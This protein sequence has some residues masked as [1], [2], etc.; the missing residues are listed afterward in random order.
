MLNIYIYLFIQREGRERERDHVWWFRCCRFHYLVTQRFRCFCEVASHKWQRK[1]GFPTNNF[2]I[3]PSSAD[4]SLLWKVPET[5]TPILENSMESSGF[6]HVRGFPC[7]GHVNFW[8]DPNL[9]ALCCEEILGTQEW[10]QA[11]E[12][13]RKMQEIASWRR[14]IFQL[15]HVEVWVTK[16]KVCIQGGAPQVISWFIIPLTIDISPMNHS[17]WSYKPT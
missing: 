11:V 3:V 5:C 17:Y 14:N 8:D 15:V 1:T 2:Q 9:N 12:V 10:R 7:L 6:V 4:V 16:M 13:L